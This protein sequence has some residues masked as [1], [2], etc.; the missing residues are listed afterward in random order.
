MTLSSTLICVFLVSCSF[1]LSSSEIALFSLSRVQLKRIKDESEPLFR[2]I[3]TLIQDS[4]GLLITVLLFNEIVNISLATILTTRIVEPLKLDWKMATLLGVLITTP[5]MLI[6]CELT[7]KVIASKANQM[8][9]SAFLPL[10]YPLYLLMKPLVAVIRFFL[11]AP[12]VRELHQLHE[13]DFIIIAE[14]QT[15]TGHLHETELELIKNVFEMDDT[16]VE[17]LATPIRKILSVPSTCNLEQACQIILKDRIYS[18]VPVYDKQKDDI[19]GVINSKDLAEV[20]IRQELRSE[21]VMTLANEPLVVSGTI[22][23]DALFRKMKSKKIQVA[24]T[25]NA[26]GKIS[27][28]ISLQDILDSLIEEAF[29]E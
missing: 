19:V 7:P 11:P 16:R 23:I 21:N 3:R 9:I 29:E 2:R 6:A 20:K 1:V 12:P 14:E 26:Q 17:Q 24:F 25:R 28:M 8:V 22:T 18:R 4:M 13:E 15:E 10:V 5:V 27:G